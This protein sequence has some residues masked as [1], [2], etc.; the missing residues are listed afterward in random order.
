[1]PEFLTSAVGIAEWAAI[2][3]FA[4]TGALAA[5]RKDMDIFGYVVLATATGIGGGSIRDVILGRL[6]LFW[7]LDMSY[8]VVCAL[9]AI[10]VFFLRRYL[11]SRQMMILWFDAVGLSLF[12]VSGAAIALKEDGIPI[13]GAIVLGVVSATFG[14]LLRDIL[15]D[16]IPLILR[17]EIYVT[18]ALLG[19]VVYV[20]ALAV[21]TPALAA[22]LGFLACFLLRGLAIHY[23]WQLPNF[24]TDRSGKP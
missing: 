16:E 15:A 18:A 4:A 9:V 12:C 22:V 20:C 23:G 19:A 7:I 13:L 21:V 24:D 8:V 3:V 5:S 10:A 11:A 1:M 17:Q 6:P 14:G 2:A